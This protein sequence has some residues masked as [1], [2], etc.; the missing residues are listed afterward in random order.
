M[1]ITQAM[2]TASSKLNLEVVGNACPK[3]TE[4]YDFRLLSDEACVGTFAINTLKIGVTTALA[5]FD[6]QS[7]VELSLCLQRE[8][9]ERTVD[10]LIAFPLAGHGNVVAGKQNSRLPIRTGQVGIWHSRRDR[11]VVTSYPSNET[12]RYLA[13]RIPTSLIENYF[14]DDIALDLNQIED[15]IVPM[16]PAIQMALHQYLEAPFLGATLR[17][18]LESKVLELIAL[19]I[20]AINETGVERRSNFYTGVKPLGSD[21]V[22]RIYRARDRL[23]ADMEDPPSL[24]DLAKSVGINQQKLKCGFRQVFGTTAF[25]YL[26]AHRLER[27]RQ[28]LVEGKVSVS[29]AA[30]VV[31]Y[32]HFGHFASIFR[33][34]FGVSP[35][36]VKRGISVREQGEIL[37]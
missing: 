33:K 36:E 1:T 7:D 5:D 15:R 30:L 23:I 9:A 4:G 37:H 32:S 22:S 28:L 3:G 34:K 26:Q 6:F 2:L 35:S 10:L 14:D 31:G 27:T 20:A 19:S 21:E 17:L 12:I 29:E 16:S 8:L 18:F 11:S 25:T 13:L 24:F